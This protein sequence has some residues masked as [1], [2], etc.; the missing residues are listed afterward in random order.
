MTNITTLPRGSRDN[1]FGVCPIC[2]KQ[3]GSM[4]AG[5]VNWI[6]CHA[7]RVKWTI[8]SNVLSGWRDLTEEEM[9]AA[10]AKLATYREVEPF[11]ICKHGTA[12]ER[13]AYAEMLRIADRLGLHLEICTE[14]VT[15]P[16]DPVSE[17]MECPF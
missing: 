7:H 6:V 3:N 4:F 15:D 11:D 17:E 1:L 16:N 2:R 14:Y 9:L 5:R 12:E 8:G 10:V 13:E